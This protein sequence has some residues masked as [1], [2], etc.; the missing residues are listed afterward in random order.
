MNIKKISLI[1]LTIATSF[2]LIGCG[3]YLYTKSQE[4][5]IYKDAQSFVNKGTDNSVSEGSIREEILN[6]INDDGGKMTL[7]DYSLSPSKEY[8][9]VTNRTPRGAVY[10]S[11]LDLK[12]K[13]DLFDSYTVSGGGELNSGNHVWT[14]DNKLILVS[15]FNAEGGEGFDGILVVNLIDQTFYRLVDMTDIC[16]DVSLSNCMSGYAFDIKSITDEKVRYEVSF[17]SYSIGQD[18]SLSYSK[19]EA[20]SLR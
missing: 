9:Y 18:P 11:L 14:D 19:E 5:R 17:D 13:K 7:Y 15:N 4:I 1:F 20:I 12:N 8:A 6:I 10:Y 2:F 16:P 3:F